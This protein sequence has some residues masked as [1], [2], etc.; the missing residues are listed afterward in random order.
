M[1][2]SPDVRARRR[3]LIALR[4]DFHRHPELGYRERRTASI[5]A[6]RLRRDGYI[7]RTA[8]GKTGVV[9]ILRGARP[10]KTLLIRADM[11]ALPIR[12]E[13]R[14]PYASTVRGVMHA[15]GHDGHT[16]IG[17]VA[18]QVLA[19]RRDR[20]AGTLKFVF[21]PAEE[22]LGGAMAM[23]RDG[24][25]SRPKPD[26][27]I[28]LHLWNGLP[29][30]TVGVREGATWAS[31]DVIE[32][33][34]AGR[35]GHAGYP[36]T[37]IDPVVVAAETVLALQT[38]VSRA[39]PPTAPAAVSI[40]RIAGGTTTNVIP[41]DVT[42]HGTMRFY[43]EGL[44]AEAKRRIGK[45]AAGVAAAH[46]AVC[47]VRF[48]DG[49]P[50]TVND[51]RLVA[52]VRK[53]AA[54]VVGPKRL[55]VHAPT[56]GSEDMGYVFQRV[57]GCYVMIGSMNPARGLDTP[58]HHPRFD[59]DEAALPLGAELLVRTAERFLADRDAAS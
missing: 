16:A 41:P 21:Q 43:D 14:S 25:L 12:E 56:M 1:N 51:P 28:A 4:R 53:S 29:V 52:L 22:E 3:D 31:S 18:A 2:L 59:F 57:P 26:G 23:I 44:R 58:H 34:I 32:I 39:L 19:G 9:G 20:L 40:T 10:G 5:V 33:A 15:C 13:R 30:G 6:R 45:I 50:V 38:V 11:D 37:T 27:A 48:E 24:L 47:R 7:V 55:V 35:G 8:V 17:L 46:G 54:D 42:L 36:H 49:Y